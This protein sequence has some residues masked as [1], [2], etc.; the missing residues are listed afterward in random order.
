ME[1]RTEGGN[2]ENAKLEFKISPK[3]ACSVYGLWRFPVTLYFS[4]WVRLLDAA[5]ELRQFLEDH[6]NDMKLKPY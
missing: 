1:V 5:A 2:M 4:Q 3:G 6:K